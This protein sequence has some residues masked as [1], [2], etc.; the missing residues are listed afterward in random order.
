MSEKP[1]KHSFKKIKKIYLS[2]YSYKTVL[3]CECGETKERKST[4]EEEQEY[5]NQTHCKSCGAELHEHENENSCLKVMYSYIE[6][7][8]SRISGLESDIFDLKNKFN[9]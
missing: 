4:P 7:L 3:E 1:H 6:R 9:F 5:V 2:L 8:E